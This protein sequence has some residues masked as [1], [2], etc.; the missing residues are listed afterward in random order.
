MPIHAMFRWYIG[1]KSQEQSAI[2]VDYCLHYFCTVLKYDWV[3][4]YCTPY[5][6]AFKPKYIFDMKR[7]N[8]YITFEEKRD[9]SYQQHFKFQ[10][11][12]Y[13]AWLFMPWKTFSWNKADWNTNKTTKERQRKTK[14]GKWEN[15]LPHWYTL[16]FC[17][18]LLKN[19]FIA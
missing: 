8:L 17:I 15:E 1:D 4:I 18:C 19:P 3:G 6:F 14:W 12:T 16:D 2:F 5:T 9:H 10:I 7:R 13:F 11:T